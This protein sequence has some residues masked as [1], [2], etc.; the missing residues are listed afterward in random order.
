MYISSHLRAS[1]LFKHLITR[2]LDEIKRFNNL[3]LPLSSQA[4]TGTDTP[5]TW[6]P[7]SGTSTRAAWLR[8]T[9]SGIIP[10]KKGCTLGNIDWIAF[11][12]GTEWIKGLWVVLQAELT[13]QLY[14]K[15]EKRPWRHCFQLF[16]K[17][18]FNVFKRLFCPPIAK[19]HLKKLFRSLKT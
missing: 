3:F 5:N 11:F 19:I 2:Y 4:V 16:S 13:D 14:K 12:C 15:T 10:A 18:F 1:M 7:R 9:G 17:Y 8:T 6:K